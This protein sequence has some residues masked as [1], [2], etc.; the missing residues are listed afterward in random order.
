MGKV[1]KIFPIPILIL[2]V[3]LLTNLIVP[4]AL[5]GDMIFLANAALWATVIASTIILA[6]KYP[7]KMWRIDKTII[8]P[9]AII[10]TFQLFLVIFV[11]FFMGFGKNTI[12][13]T[14]RA[15]TILFPFLLMPFLG[16]E[17]SRAYLARTIGHRKPT[18]TL[19]L[20]SLFY[21]LIIISI[22]RYTS[23]TTPLAISEFLIKSFIPTLAISLLATYFA[24]LGNFSANLIYMAIPALFTWF[25]PILPNPP[26]AVQCIINVTAPTIG[27]L[28]LNQA[29][30]SLPTR[31]TRRILKKQ[32]SQL[33][34][35]TVIALIAL[36]A[37]W[38]STGL[39]GFTPTI[40]ASGSMAP[41]LNQGDITIIVSAPT[42]TIKI[43]DTIQYYTSDVPIIHRVIDKYETGGSLWFI[44]KGDA[45]TEPDDPI[46]ERQVIGKVV[47]TIP[48][49]GWISIALKDFAV[50]TYTFL[51]TTM[52]QV[53]ANGW[54][55]ITTNCIYIA[56]ALVFTSYSYFL[57][58][59]KHHKKEEET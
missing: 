15:L 21:T 36:I 31:K 32:K 50:H 7:T 59:Y 46:N 27:F 8:Q 2:T 24:Y 40:I 6:N 12:T 20:I 57:L 4:T 42:E 58:T 17:L 9:A 16:V 55:W 23:L 49:L 54:T 22:P 5:R 43:G 44:T 45:N 56:S 30:I 19:F 25:S 14:P 37:V 47:L 1:K 39:L 48:Q 18:L 10:A 41:T 35:W 34:Y 51:A 38:S 52:S 53:L 3:Y 29:T 33:P 28:F 13:W 11:S 26:W